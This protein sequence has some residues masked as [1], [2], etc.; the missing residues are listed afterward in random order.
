MRTLI[1]ELG[2]ADSLPTLSRVNGQDSPSGPVL[3]PS[4]FW[5]FLLGICL[6][7]RLLLWAQYDAY[8]K[9]AYLYIFLSDQ[10]DQGNFRPLFEYYDINIYPLILVLGHRLGLSWTAAGVS[11]G[12]LA[13]SLTILPLYGWLRR[14]ANDRIALCGCLLYASH[15][16][17]VELAVEPIRDTTFW[18]FLNLTFYFA[19]RA[20]QQGKLHFYLAAGL[21]WV[22]S[23]YTRT[24]GWF[25]VIPL[26]IWIAAQGLFVPGRRLR[27]LA[28]SLGLVLM[29][30]LFVIVVNCT[31]FPKEPTWHLGSLRHF[32]TVWTWATQP[33]NDPPPQASVEANESRDEKLPT[34]DPPAQAVVLP[35]QDLAEENPTNRESLEQSQP[36]PLQT[37]T[38]PHS[39]ETANAAFLPRLAGYLKKLHS[40]LE[41]LHYLLLG[42]GFCVGWNQ[43]WNQRILPLIAL[44]A[45]QGLA[46]WILISTYGAINPRYFLTAYLL[47]LP[48]EAL[49]LLHFIRWISRMRAQRASSPEAFGRVALIAVG[50]LFVVGWV[51]A[52]VYEHPS[53]TAEL[54]FADWLRTSPYSNAEIAVDQGTKRIGYHLKETMPPVLGSP[55]E[56]ATFRPEN[57][58]EIVIVSKC[59]L[60]PDQLTAFQERASQWNYVPISN[61]DFPSS[62]DITILVQKDFMLKRALPRKQ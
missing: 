60:P 59:S 23:A 10:I 52:F 2:D 25:L 3:R 51:D 7:P 16:N 42:L 57:P 12:I 20:V 27:T 33:A 22:M 40:A 8:C 18:F 5:L 46:I 13:G 21:A 38:I 29:I 37:A 48:I 28:G 58:P 49:G 61:P 53:R 55:W 34:N 43:I 15:P 44:A 26:S 6:I 32:Q 9:D 54:K 47:C 36:E 17:L 19:L 50:V 11:W 14:V 24:E 30:P 31:A 45:V 41:P 56:L 35:S 62:E 4:W 1:N 39:V